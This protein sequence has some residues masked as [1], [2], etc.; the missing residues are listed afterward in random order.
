M[1]KYFSL[2]LLALGVLLVFKYYN[3]FEGYS[4]YNLG[5]ASG[6][7]PESQSQVLVQDIYPSIGRNEISDNGSANIWWHY[8][9]FKL[10]SYKQETNHIRYP[11]NPDEGRCM[12]ASMCGAVYHE[13][14]IGENVI[15]VLPPV[16]PDAGTRIGYF[17][18]NNTIITSLPYKTD[19]ANI[20]Y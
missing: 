15:D 11:N 20:L 5:L 19:M 2:I 12:P 9:T 14:K 13:K 8:P 18:T 17:A 7:F 16:C 1:K 3:K 6:D 4:N 10:G